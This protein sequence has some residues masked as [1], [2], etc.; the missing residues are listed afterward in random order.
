MVHFY[1]TSLSLEIT[2][3]E[4]VYIVNVLKIWFLLSYRY[5]SVACPGQNQSP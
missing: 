2:Q 5:I 1:K 3:I 4:F